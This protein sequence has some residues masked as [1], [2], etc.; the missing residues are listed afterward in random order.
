MLFTLVGG[1]LAYFGWVVSEEEQTNIVLTVASNYT[2]SADG[3]EPMNGEN[4]ALVPTSCTDTTR[5]IKR[6]I[7]V[8]SSINKA[9]TISNMALWLDINKIDDVLSSSKHFRYA[10]TTDDSSCDKGVITSGNFSG[11]SKG[12]KISLFNNRKIIQ[13]QTDTDFSR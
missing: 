12:S 4:V 7:R 13:R 6:E 3:G 8:S 9:G 2:C 10:L 5:A 1:T 11:T